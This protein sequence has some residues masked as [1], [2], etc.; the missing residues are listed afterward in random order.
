[1]KEPPTP[2]GAAEQTEMSGERE[3]LKRNGRA[4]RTARSKFEGSRNQASDLMSSEW[5]EFV[6]RY[7]H[8]AGKYVTRT[9]CCP[10]ATV[11]C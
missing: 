6:I 7:D 2:D 10:G 8:K 9:A 1:M 5:E 3:M 11:C 4:A